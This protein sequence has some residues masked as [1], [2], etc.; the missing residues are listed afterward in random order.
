MPREAVDPITEF[1]IGDLRAVRADQRHGA[2]PLRH[3]RGQQ[4]GQRRPARVDRQIVPGRV[5]RHQRSIPLGGIEQV[6]VA[7]R[8]GRRGHDRVE[9]AAE[10]IHEALHRV[11][12]EQIGGVGE[13]A[14]DALGPPGVA[15]AVGRDQVQIEL[16]DVRVEVDAGHLQAGQLEIGAGQ[17]LERQAHLEQRMPGR[18]PHRI[19]RLHQALERHVRVGERRDIYLALARQQV[20]ERLAGVHLGPEDQGVDEHTDQVVERG[21]TTTGHRGADRDVVGARQPGQQ[22]GQRGVHH[23]EQRGTLAARQFDQRP[24]R[25]ATHLEFD[26]ATGERLHRRARPIRR[27]VQL[28]RQAGQRLPPVG[29]LFGGHR[30]RILFVAEQFALP[31]AVVRVLDRQRRP[32]GRGAGRAGR[33]RGHQIPG[34]R[35]HRGAVAGDVVHHHGEHEFGRGSGDPVERH[36]HRHLGG[37]VEGRVGQIDDRGLDALDRHRADL[38]GRDRVR[39]R[40]DDLYRTAVGLRVHRPQD[41]VPRHHIPHRRLQRRYVQRA[42][43]PHGDRHVV[44]RGGRIVFPGGEPVEEP[45]PLLRQRQRNPFGPWSGR[46][47]LPSAR[48]RVL[49]DAGRQRGHGGRLEQQAHRHPRVQRLAEPGRDLRREQ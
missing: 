22:H 33:V 30:A 20:G 38:D 36:P 26:P 21:L 7:D 16:R 9:Q 31:D 13:E 43:Q 10:A 35:A 2:G 37:D 40:Q 25:F 3:G 12:I 11:S 45:H 48:A 34:Q 44:G 17:V 4:G 18:R 28:I 46:E 19:Q 1:G 29:D 39:D 24:V 49:L 14:A 32:R 5:A 8:H 23:H 41:L 27:Q 6:V 42:G 47:R 15:V